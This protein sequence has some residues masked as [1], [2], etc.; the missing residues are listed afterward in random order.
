[1]N[2]PLQH[3]RL[4][5]GLLGGI[6][7]G[8]STVSGL[9]ATFGPGKVLDAD[10]LARAALV[11]C[12]KDGRLAEALGP[13]AIGKDGLPDRKAIAKKV[14]N[15]P[16]AL[17]ALERLTH[18]AVLA[19]I[20]D[21][22]E[23]HRAGKGEPILVLDVPLLIEVGLERRCDALW[24]VAAPDEM[25]FSRAEKRLGLSKAEVL[26]REATQSPLDRK[27]GRA[28]LV[29]DNSGAPDALTAQVVKGLQA[30][31]CRI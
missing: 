20:N 28:D 2:A 27:R 5:I 29:I 23:D 9:I 25:R 11:Q 31:G 18:P 22:V 10:A 17:R 15:E 26:E 19:A 13:K 24:F 30:L 4:I 7:S 16:P 14:F 6:A 12:A 1:M 21:A 3:P 8:K